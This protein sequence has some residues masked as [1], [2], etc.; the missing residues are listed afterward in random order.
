MFGEWIGKYMVRYKTGS[1]GEHCKQGWGLG[2]MDSNYETAWASRVFSNRD[3]LAGGS[4]AVGATKK[5]SWRRASQA[6]AF[7]EAARTG[8][9]PE[10]SENEGTPV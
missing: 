9:R 6:G 3:R 7:A 1:G 5:E 8:P 10:K 2:T 4:L